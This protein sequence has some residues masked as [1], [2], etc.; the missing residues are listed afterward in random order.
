MDEVGSRWVFKTKLN[1]DH[2]ID[3]YKARLAAKGYSYLEGIDFEETFSPIVKATTIR[4]M[5]SIVVSLK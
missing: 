1:S 2:S 3:K 5:L 4:V